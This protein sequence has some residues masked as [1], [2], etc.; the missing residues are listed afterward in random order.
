MVAGFHSAAK[1]LAKHEPII[2]LKAHTDWGKGFNAGVKIRVHKDVEVSEEAR[3][4]D[5]WIDERNALDE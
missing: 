2:L 4:W 5:T 3:A 1:H